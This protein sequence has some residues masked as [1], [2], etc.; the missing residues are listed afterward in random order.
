MKTGS[1]QQGAGKPKH[2]KS[3][4][5][6]LIGALLIVLYSS[7]E[8]YQLAKVPRIGYLTGTQEPTRDSPDTNRDAFRQGLRDLGYIERKNIFVEYRYAATNPDR[9]TSLVAE[10]L[11]LQVDVI[12][13]PV[14]SGIL[15]AQEATKT[16]PIVI[17]TNQDPVAMGLANSF[18][19][20]GGNITGLTRFTRELAGKRLELLKE[21]V[22][23]TS[24]VAVLLD[25]ESTVARNAFR[26]YETAGKA[27]KIPLQSLGL[28]SSKS[29]FERAF[30]TAAKGRVSSIIVLRNPLLI[31]NRKR[32]AELAI[33]NRL[34]S[35]SEGSVFVGAGALMSYSSDEN[36]SF[37][38][39]A[40][41]V[42]KI[43]KGAKPAEL[44]IEQPTK[45]ELVIN[46]KTAK[47][48]GLKIPPNVLARADKVIR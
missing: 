38:R 18:A 44:P 11:H 23:T 32:I 16:I 12:V 40:F 1:G 22:A 13:S 41:Y 29:D 39:A 20:P 46:L 6:F 3:I 17:V 31:D 25:A 8:A 14:A 48:L 34:P 30:Q 26:E 28:R 45:F 42:D 10:L 21:I 5:C 2:R 37:R 47:Q 19:R 35:M 33:R 43:L 4:F 9:A 15:A 27:L 36:H 7:V 24:G